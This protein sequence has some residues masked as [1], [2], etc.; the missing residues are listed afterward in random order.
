MGACLSCWRGRLCF[1]RRRDKGFCLVYFSIFASVLTGGGCVCACIRAYTHRLLRYL[2]WAQVWDGH[3]ESRKQSD[4]L[5]LSIHYT[6][7]VYKVHLPVSIYMLG[8]GFGLFGLATFFLLICL[9]FWEEYKMWRQSAN[10]S[11][12]LRWVTSV[13]M[14]ACTLRDPNKTTTLFFYEQS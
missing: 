2:M 6:V 12:P 10:L 3:L 11:H 4:W 5:K 14:I 1:G 9:F 13:R 8:C 7:Y